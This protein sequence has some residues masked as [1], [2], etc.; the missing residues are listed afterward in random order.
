MSISFEIT[1]LM[2][3]LSVWHC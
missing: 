3:S 1:D 2:S